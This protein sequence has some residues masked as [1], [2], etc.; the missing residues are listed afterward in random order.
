MVAAWDH[1]IPAW[2]TRLHP[3]YGTPTRSLAVI[4]L[5]AVLFS[6][7]ASSGAGASEAFQLLV[8]SG[9]ICYGFNYLL[10]FAVPL[11][12]GTRLSLRPDLRPPA[13]LRAACVCGASVTLLSII[14]NLVP[15]VDVAR[16][17]VFAIKVGLTVAGIN[18]IGA[19][20][21]WRGTRVQ[22]RA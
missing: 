20:I 9:F 18:L 15:I 17:W 10:M 16:P 7:L 21:Y 4:V 19:A 1:L 6:L 5:V 22:V 2:F 3:R 14:F 13:L 8:T 11:L 12:V